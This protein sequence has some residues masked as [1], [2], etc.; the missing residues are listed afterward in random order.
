M[1]SLTPY[2]THRN[3]DASTFIMIGKVAIL[4]WRP[5]ELLELL[6]C[7]SR[8]KAYILPCI[9]RLPYNRYVCTQKPTIERVSR[10]FGNILRTDGVPILSPIHHRMSSEWVTLIFQRHVQSKSNERGPF[11]GIIASLNQ[12]DIFRRNRENFPT[13]AF[14]IFNRAD[15]NKPP[16]IPGKPYRGLFLT[17]FHSYR[18]GS[19]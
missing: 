13:A 18:V 17:P 12:T 15:Q 8:L 4:R 6:S 2:R 9:W 1:G 19:K 11:K 7:P 16:R 5:P 3:L 14:V 10:V